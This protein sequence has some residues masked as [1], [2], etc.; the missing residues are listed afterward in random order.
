MP[1]FIYVYKVSNAGVSPAFIIAVSISACFVLTAS[2][3]VDTALGIA[4][5]FSVF[6]VIYQSV[7]ASSLATV[8]FKLL[9]KTVFNPSIF[10]S[11]TDLLFGI[12]PSV[13]S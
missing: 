9:I 13:L 2:L 12:K 8:V 11:P 1:V 3:C 6:L 4:V 7:L 5:D 10:I